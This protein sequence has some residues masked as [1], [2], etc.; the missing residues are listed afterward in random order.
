MFN[1][2]FRGESSRY[3]GFFMDFPYIRSKHGQSSGKSMGHVINS[4]SENSFVFS[5][6]KATEVSIRCRVELT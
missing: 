1:Q 2:V 5:Y 3:A 4:I 6:K